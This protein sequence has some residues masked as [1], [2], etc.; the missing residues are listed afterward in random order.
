MITV[1]AP[2]IIFQIVLILTVFGFAS[3]VRDIIKLIVYLFKR[4]AQKTDGD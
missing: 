1:E 3:M 4:K 2:F